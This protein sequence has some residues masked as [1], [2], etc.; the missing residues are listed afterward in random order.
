MTLDVSHIRDNSFIRQIIE[1][2]WH[3]IRVVHLSAK[4]ERE[5]HLPIDSFCVEVV[6]LLKDKGWQGN[7]IL[8]Y[9]PQHNY[10][11]REDIKALREHVLYG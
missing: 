4:G 2:Y 8:E 9:L 6:K 1:S 11:L 10:C 7:I 3:N 5:H